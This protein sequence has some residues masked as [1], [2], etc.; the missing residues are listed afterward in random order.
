MKTFEKPTQNNDHSGQ[1]YPITKTD[2]L[3]RPEQGSK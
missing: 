3:K 2:E 1:S